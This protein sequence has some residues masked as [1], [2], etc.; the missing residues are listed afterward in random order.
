MLTSASA[1]QLPINVKLSTLTLLHKASQQN[2]R[3]DPKVQ[4]MELELDTS[5][6]SAKKE[7][8]LVSSDQSLSAEQVAISTRFSYNNNGYGDFCFGRLIDRTSETIDAGAFEEDRDWSAGIT[9][10][11]GVP[12]VE[13]KYI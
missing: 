12:V 10:S 13:L 6:E 1:S 9:G 2:I 3:T 8:L 11:N 7:E 5:E 4:S